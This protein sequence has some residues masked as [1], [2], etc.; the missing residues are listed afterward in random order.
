M[1]TYLQNSGCTNASPMHMELN[2]ILTSVRAGSTHAQE[3]N[4]Q[5]WRAC[6]HIGKGKF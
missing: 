2:D 4:L 3:Q 5:I 6:A 1:V